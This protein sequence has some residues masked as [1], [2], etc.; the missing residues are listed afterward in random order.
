MVFFYMDFIKGKPSSIVTVQSQA[1]YSQIMEAVSTNQIHNKTLRA[2][3]NMCRAN[4]DK[5]VCV[6][7]RSY[8]NS[9]LM[10]FGE[11]PVC[12]Q[13]EGSKL[14]NIMGKHSKDETIYVFTYVK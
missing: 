11:K 2:V 5:V 1:N 13:L 6:I 12:V 4:P 10:I 14:Q 7:Y 9:V 8:E 3:V